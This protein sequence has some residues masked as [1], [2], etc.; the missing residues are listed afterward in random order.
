MYVNSTYSDLFLTTFL[1]G[2]N[3]INL[4]IKWILYISQFANLSIFQ[5]KLT[6]GGGGGGGLLSEID[7]LRRIQGK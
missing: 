2:V 1:L 5:V 3:I 7:S 6:G 4:I